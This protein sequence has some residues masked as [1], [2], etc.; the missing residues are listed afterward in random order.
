[1]FIVIQPI[2]KNKPWCPV[3]PS[4]MGIPSLFSQDWWE[5]R[6]Y[7]PSNSCLPSRLCVPHSWRRER[8]RERGW[9]HH[10]FLLGKAPKICFDW[11]VFWKIQKK[12]VHLMRKLWFLETLFSGEPTLVHQGLRLVHQSTQT[13]FLLRCSEFQL[14]E[15]V[16]IGH[17]PT[18]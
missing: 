9:Y 14:E 5:R 15:N 7:D 3:V 13:V 18:R 10:D 6:P 8:R 17:S 4:R 12:D 2:G 11:L 16:E 1:M